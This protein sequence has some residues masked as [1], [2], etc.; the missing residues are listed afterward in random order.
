MRYF[1]ERFWRALFALALSGAAAMG[2]TPD[3]ALMAQLRGADVVILGETH[4]N[5]AHHR[6]QGAILQALAPRAVVFEMLS[7]D[8]A[9]RLDAQARKDLDGLGTLLGWETS[10]WP[11]FALYRPVFAGLGDAAVIGAAVPRDKVRAAYKDGAAAVFGADAARFGL[12]EALP[13]PEQSAR[14]AAQFEAHCGAMPLAL[15]G[16]M[17]AAQRFRDAA[18]ARTVIA[19]QA[20]HGRPVV[21]IAGTGHARTDWGMPRLLAWAA[22]QLKVVS[23][24]F[25]EA[26]DP[27][28]PFD[29]R[30]P[31]APAERDDPCAAF[32]K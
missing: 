11:D 6:G 20:S 19:A 28:A 9:V 21:M 22:P 27:T 14:E 10:G 29:I 31:T 2:F 26:D 32:D 16:G 4:D 17:V 18:F 7:E 1:F 15:M 8:Q 13:E 3:A 25:L 12:H 30:I 5:A 24:G 23:V